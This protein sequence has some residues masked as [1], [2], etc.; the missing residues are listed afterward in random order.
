VSAEL[1]EENKHMLFIPKGFA[2]GFQALSKEAEIEYLVDNEYAADSDQARR[3]NFE[4]RRR[5]NK[6]HEVITMLG[7]GRKSP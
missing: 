7:L 3:S 2:H 5:K 1:T 6:P 4:D